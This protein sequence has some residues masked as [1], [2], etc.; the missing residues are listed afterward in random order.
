M[1]LCSK[2]NQKAA[3]V[4]LTNVM[5]G[6]VERLD[7]CQDCAPATG[8]GGLTL[9]QFMALSV[10][11]KQCE[12]CGGEALGGERGSNSTI[13]L[14]SDCGFERGQIL[15]ELLA[16]EHPDWEQRL[17]ENW[18]A[19][20][21]DFQSELMAWWEAASQKAIQILRDRRRRDGRDT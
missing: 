17:A 4:H 7:F 8:Y 20:S 13:Y 14:C 3:T 19:L 15:E 5:N 18:S 9:D 2:C 10:D 12:F 6:T 16:S 11:G 1:P 21:M